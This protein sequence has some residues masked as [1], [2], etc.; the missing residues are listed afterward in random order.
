MHIFYYACLIIVMEILLSE[1]LDTKFVMSSRQLTT[2]FVIKQIVEH[3]NVLQYSNIL[4]LNTKKD[5]KV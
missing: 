5:E 3:A 2:P 1:F 4:N